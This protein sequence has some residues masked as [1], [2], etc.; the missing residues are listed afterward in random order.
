MV[1]RVALISISL[2]FS[3]LRAATTPL[4][5]SD[6]FNQA[7]G[8]PPDLTK[9]TFDLGGGGWGN[10]ELESYT[11]STDN[12]SVVSDPSATDGKALAIRAI[13]SST[14]GYTSGRIKTQGKFTATYGR[15]EARIKVPSGQGIWPA[16]W[17]LGNNI[18]TVGW[19]TCG[20]IDILEILGQNPSK[21][22]GT[23]HGPGYSGG[24]GIQGTYTLP[25]GGRF[26]TDYH[27]FA[28]QWSPGKIDW[29]V[30]GIVYHTASPASLPQGTKWVYDNSPFFIILNLAVGGGFPGNPDGT[31]TFPQVLYV[32]YVRVYSLTPAAPAKIAGYASSGNQVNLTWSPPPDTSGS[33]L[34][35]YRVERAADLAF[36]QKLVSRDIGLVTSFADTSA[37]LGNTYF[38]RISAITNGGVSDP[39]A[40]F[41]VSMSSATASGATRLISLSARAQVGLGADIL[42]AGFVVSGTGSKNVLVRGIGPALANF[43]V[44]GPLLD[45]ILSIYDSAGRLLAINDNWSD[46]ANSADIAAT[47]A[48]VGAFP[49]VS[50]SKDAAMLL[51]LLPGGY[52]AQVAGA[53]NTTGVA[54]AE[55]YE[56]SP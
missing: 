8:S 53:N 46:N 43:G 51:A 20:E 13:K 55:V 33:T 27:I 26:D 52:S 44:S 34:I 4:I 15:F 18:G 3:P 37:Q 5:W 35:G 1:L 16:F 54:L 24:H 30:D 19:P 56:V 21:L 12:V 41:Q 7:D 9:W 36:T 29:S 40:V 48:A 14:G 47:A 42:I 25:N 31:T 38:Y 2:A 11:D 39:S 10:N 32:D 17:M 49:L 45:P 50:G 6:E 22:Y 23:L 28:V